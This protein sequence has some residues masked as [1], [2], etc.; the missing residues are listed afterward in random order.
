MAKAKRPKVPKV[1]TNFKE[2]GKVTYIYLSLPLPASD[3]ETPETLTYHVRG[4]SP[5]E[6]TI[7]IAILNSVER[8]RP[9]MKKRISQ[10]LADKLVASELK[11]EEY[12]DMDDPTYLDQTRMFLKEATIIADRSDMYKLVCGVK[13]FDLTDEEIRSELETEPEPKNPQ[14]SLLLRLDQIR[15]IILTDANQVHIDALMAKIDELSGV[16]VS[17]IN[18]T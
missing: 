15:K 12:F 11:E 16:D 8:P 17:R 5:T 4:L 6:D 13:G 9:P 10:D 1:V 18:F 3:D 14:T 7:R 2:I